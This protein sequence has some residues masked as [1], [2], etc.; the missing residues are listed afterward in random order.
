M[1][2]RSGH[3]LNANL[4]EYGLP[5]SMDVPAQIVAIDPGTLDLATNT[6][7]KGMGEPPVTGAGGAIANAVYNA[8]GVRIRDYPITPNKILAALKAK[9]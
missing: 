8:I 7:V 6:N 9:A 3:Q 2:R 5:T 1:D 4:H